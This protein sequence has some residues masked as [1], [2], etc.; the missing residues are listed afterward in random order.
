MEF[1]ILKLS[2]NEE[3]LLWNNWMKSLII[4][5]KF[6]F[7]LRNNFNAFRHI[8]PEVYLSKLDLRSELYLS[9]Q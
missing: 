9:T 4:S 7:Y 6:V 2:L 5:Y 3:F 1:E 8:F